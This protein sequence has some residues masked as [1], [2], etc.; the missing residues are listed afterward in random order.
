MV[1]EMVV[2]E[3]LSNELIRAGKS[4]TLLL[5]ENQFNVSASLWFYM[6]DINNWRFIVASSEVSS[7][8]IKSAYEHVQ[9]I[10]STIPENQPKITLKDISLFSPLDPLISLLKIAIKT[11]DGISGIRFSQ[12]M[13][14]GILIDDA[15][16]YRLT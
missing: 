10:I 2:K 16:I 7:K 12:N 9:Q 5:D 1:T 14:N 3:S 4:L 11:G 8:G 13:I 6:S 15:Y